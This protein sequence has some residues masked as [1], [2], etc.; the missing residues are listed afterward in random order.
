MTPFR[1]TV[2]KVST[3]IAVFL[4]AAAPFAAA[5]QYGII[6]CDDHQYVK[7]LDWVVAGLGGEGL[8]RK[9]FTDVGNAI[10][11]PLTWISY[12]ADYTV[13]KLA[14]A[15]PFGLMHAGSIAVHALN[16]VCVWW[17]LS[18]L[19]CAGKCRFVSVFATLFWAMHPLRVESVVW[20][21]SRKDVLSM[22]WL[23]LS[24]ISWVKWRSGRGRLPYVASM[25]FFVCGAMCKPSVMVFPILCILVDWITGKVPRN[26]SEMRSPDFWG[27]DE[28]RWI[29]GYGVP[30]F[31]S[32]AV[33]YSAMLVQGLGGATEELS[34]VPLWWR[35]LNAATSL[36]IYLLHV[37][38][39]V[40]LCIQPQCRYPELPRLAVAGLATCAVLLYAGWRLWKR[41]GTTGNS[42]DRTVFC[43]LLWFAVSL[44]PFLGI[45]NFGE[46]AFADRFTYIPALGLSVAVSVAAARFS[47]IAPR[48]V[49]AG[50]MGIC[51]LLGFLSWRQTG[52]WK[53]S[54]SIWSRTLEVDGAKNHNALM[55]CAEYYFDVTHD[56]E[57]AI[58]Y[59]DQLWEVKP[60]RAGGIADFHVMALCE[61]GR[62]D[63]AKEVL[64]KYREWVEWYLNEMAKK[65][66][67]PMQSFYQHDLARCV[68]LMGDKSL[69]KI[70]EEE[71]DRLEKIMPPRK[72][73]LY[74]KGLLFRHLGYDR[75]AIDCWKKIDTV[76]SN[77]KM[78]FAFV[79]KMIDG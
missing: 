61:L 67:V 43:G 4:L 54:F 42:A 30:V 48:N 49:F 35:L 10:W 23:L 65:G 13:S 62:R 22:F 29:L 36:G 24:L 34:G 40:D 55:S 46:H 2:R 44:V 70:A 7:D 45:A 53:D 32:G 27:R 63:E 68:Y 79:K 19:G 76:K 59:F 66:H 74:V 25:A 69:V 12:A 64:R 52:F 15:D 71:I 5:V 17:F 73:L 8:V 60:K 51:A 39:P 37:F 18:L 11:M 26:I 47:Q 16:A 31:L 9:A 33:A 20:I 38:W 77:E 50:S 28:V 21:A 6:D 72:D 1:K 56:L 57:K 75:K 58:S 41:M 78:A 14:G 3:A